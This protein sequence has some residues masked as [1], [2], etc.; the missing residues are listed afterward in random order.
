MPKRVTVIINSIK[1]KPFSL[2]YLMKNI[3]F[4]NLFLNVHNPSLLNLA[5]KIIGAVEIDF[6]SLPFP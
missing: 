4:L 6:T 5:L 3:F 2:K 1:E